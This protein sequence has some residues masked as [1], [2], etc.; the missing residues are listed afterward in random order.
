MRNF[1][2]LFIALSIATLTT[3]CSSR[4]N[5]V[6]RYEKLDIAGDLIYILDTKTGTIYESNI[7]DRYIT[8]LTLEGDLMSKKYKKIDLSDEQ[9]N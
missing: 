7:H 1:K 4:N 3:S 8:E 9:S 2:L 6:G 5:D